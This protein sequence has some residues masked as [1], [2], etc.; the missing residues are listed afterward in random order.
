M[1]EDRK[2][3]K[4]ELA[5]YKSKVIS[6]TAVEDIHEMRLLELEDDLQNANAEHIELRLKLKELAIQN[7]SL[8]ARLIEVNES[9]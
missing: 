9:L 8:K 4:S 5:T 2:D 1:R 7:N 6:G 3:I